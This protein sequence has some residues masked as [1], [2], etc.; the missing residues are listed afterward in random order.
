MEPFKNWRGNPIEVAK[1]AGGVLAVA[2]PWN[3]VISSFRSF[4]KAGRSERT[5]IRNAPQLPPK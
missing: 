4:T 5:L 3:N 1:S 2:D